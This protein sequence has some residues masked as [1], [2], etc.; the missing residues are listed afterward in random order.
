[1]ASKDH[2]TNLILTG[3]SMQFLSLSFKIAAVGNF[4]PKNLR[5]KDKSSYSRVLYIIV[6]NENLEPKLF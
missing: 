3:P 4:S 1:M 2:F 6:T 5:A